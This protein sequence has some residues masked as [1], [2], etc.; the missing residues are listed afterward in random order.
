MYIGFVARL[1]KTSLMQSNLFS[2][3]KIELILG[4]IDLVRV[5]LVTS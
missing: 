1:V 5:D 4:Q 2:A 3:Q